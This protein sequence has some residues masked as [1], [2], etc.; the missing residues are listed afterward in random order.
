MNI[1]AAYDLS[2]I[3]P[4]YNVEEYVDECLASL[5]LCT[6]KQRLEILIID[7]CS[8]DNTPTRCQE[9]L[10]QLNN[11]RIIKHSHNQGAAAARNT[12]LDAAQGSYICFIDP[13]DTLPVD[14][15]QKLYDTA[16][17]YDAD[18]V[19]GNNTL[20]NDKK[21]VAAGYNCKSSQLLR[22]EEV[23]G[24]LLAQELVRGHPWGKIF[25]RACIA[26][27]RFPIGVRMAEDLVF[28]AEVFSNASKFILLDQTTYHYRLRKTGASGSKYSSGAYLDWL[29]SIDRCA[30]FVRTK[31]QEKQYIKLQVRTL[32]QLVREALKIEDEQ[33]R[34]TVNQE[35]HKQLKTWGLSKRRVI[36]EKLGLSVLFRLAKAE[37]GLRKLNKDSS[38]ALQ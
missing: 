33:C 9:Q 21:S 26:N 37:R 3:I 14:A 7:D 13:D 10:S 27:T 25:K 15:L 29:N 20:F 36:K 28:C 34:L 6:F 12:G 5:A 16:T 18:I 22:G 4:A 23:L 2:V 11:A 19:K 32:L 17:H 35:V 8:T 24:C 1:P 38:V 31:F 30:H